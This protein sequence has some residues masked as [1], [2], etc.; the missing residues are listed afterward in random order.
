MADW[1]AY[2]TGLTGLLT[3]LGG[4]WLGGRANRNQA[5]AQESADSLSWVRQAKAEADQAKTDAIE[6]ESRAGRAE[7][8]A[9]R[10][11]RRLEEVERRMARAERTIESLMEWVET[12]VAAAHDPDATEQDLRDIINGGPPGMARRRT[13]G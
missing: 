4:L 10:A 6:A 1:G 5:R 2:A 11:E 3:A 9:D 13:H 8:R 7:V 12:V